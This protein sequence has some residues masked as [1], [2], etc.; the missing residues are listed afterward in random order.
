MTFPAGFFF[1]SSYFKQVYD[2]V[3]GGHRPR[4][5]EV[6]ASGTDAHV[7]G[8]L[9]TNVEEAMPIFNHKAVVELANLCEL[10]RDG[11]LENGEALQILG[12]L[13]EVIEMQQ[14]EIEQLKAKVAKLD[15]QVFRVI[16][17]EPGGLLE[18]RRRCGRRRYVSFPGSAL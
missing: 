12:L 5:P 15:G 9:T 14:H 8:S 3:A 13:G 7:F 1:L 4:L 6:P 17:G 10:V 11:G 16:G 2:H 18:S